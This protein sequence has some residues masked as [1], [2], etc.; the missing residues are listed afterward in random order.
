MFDEPIASADEADV[1]PMYVDWVKIPHSCEK[2]ENFGSDPPK[3]PAM[4]VVVNSFGGASAIMV[5]ASPS[6]QP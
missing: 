1:C 6:K 2:R 4:R 5:L 3:R